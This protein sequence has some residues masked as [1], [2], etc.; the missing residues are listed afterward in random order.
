MPS[1][2]TAFQWMVNACNS[3]NI[4]YSQ[5]YR[6]GQTVNGITYYDCS[7]IISQA[8]TVAGY[9]TQNPWFTTYTMGS[10][11]TQI[12]A[13]HYSSSVAWIPGD[14]LVVNSATIQHTEMVYTG[15]EAG[16]GG[17]TMGAHT[18]QAPLADQVSINDFVT[19]SDY[20]TDLYRLPGGATTLSWIAKNAYLTEA[21]MQNNAYVFYSTMYFKGWT[22]NAIAGALGCMQHESTINPGIWE[23][24]IESPE[25]GFGLVQWTPST[26]YT[27]WADA[28][29]YAHDDGAGQ[30]EWIDTQ[31]GL[32]QWIPTTAYPMSWDEFKASTESPE[33][34]SMAWMNNFERPGVIYD[35]QEDA[36]KWYNYLENISPYP[37]TPGERKRKMPLWMY[38]YPV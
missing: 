11:L 9:F 12:G 27:L 17:I 5:A 28:N 2:N 26:N 32:G 30:C 10:Y 15:G 3:P 22:L 36:K 6:R 19:Q 25:R 38:L 31:S 13:E 24:L 34:L 18:D 23:G 16:Q 8:L 37:P 1:L 14:I 35:P 21:E 20:Y 4:G 33:Y 7:S 29:G